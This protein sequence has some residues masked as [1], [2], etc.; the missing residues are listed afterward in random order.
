MNGE[1]LSSERDRAHMLSF[2]GCALRNEGWGAFFVCFFWLNG[3]RHVVITCIVLSAVL[4]ALCWEGRGVELTD[5]VVVNINGLCCP[6]SSSRF[7]LRGVGELFYIVHGCCVV[8]GIAACSFIGPRVML[9]FFVLRNGT[10][11]VM[12]SKSF[13][14]P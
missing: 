11:L 13:C 8:Q 10:V 14:I 3:T 7:A 12:D 9:M 5:E 6:P 2:V 1:T 4:F